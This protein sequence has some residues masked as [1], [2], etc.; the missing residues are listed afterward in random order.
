MM[1]PFYINVHGLFSLSP[2]TLFYFR[3][4]MQTT[5]NLS[6][7]PLMGQTPRTLRL[8]SGTLPSHRRLPNRHV[9]HYC[10]YCSKQ[11]TNPTWL[12]KHVK[13]K[14]SAE[15]TSEWSQSL[16]DMIYS[17]RSI[18]NSA[19][20]LSQYSVPQELPHSSLIR[21][22]QAMS[23]SLKSFLPLIDNLVTLLQDPSGIPSRA[24][25]IDRDHLRDLKRCSSCQDLHEQNKR[26]GPAT[27]ASDIAIPRT[28]DP[29]NLDDLENQNASPAT[30]LFD[31]EPDSSEHSRHFSRFSSFEQ[32]QRVRVPL[33]QQNT[34]SS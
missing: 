33:S 9:I 34:L 1:S 17:R 14:H 11:Y 4:P 10:P 18:A 29:M 24:H 8:D 6:E 12:E 20:L 31:G 7:D 5:L 2:L 3:S 26:R 23:S 13:D 19:T 30:T 21:D 32:V 15:F 27:S 25:S 16:A 28:M 22:L